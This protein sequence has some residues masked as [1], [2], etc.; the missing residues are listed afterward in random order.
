MRRFLER[1]KQQATKKRKTLFDDSEAKDDDYFMIQ[2]VMRE[3]L[4]NLGFAERC[5]GTKDEAKR[6]VGMQNRKLLPKKKDQSKN[7][8]LWRPDR[9]HFSKPMKEILEAAGFD[10]Y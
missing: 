6:L 10:C 2:N 1:E 4:N 9:L 5:F 3:E 8:M 7:P